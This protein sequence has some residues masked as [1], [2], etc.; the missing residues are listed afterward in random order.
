VQGVGEVDEDERHI[1]HLSLNEN[2]WVLAAQLQDETCKRLH[3]VLMREP[4][5]SEGKRIHD[6]YTLK[7]NRVYKVTPDGLPW[8]VPKTARTVFYHHD[9]VGHFGVDKTLDLVRQ[10]YW[11]PQMEKYNK[12]YVSC[13]L[14]CMYKK[15]PTGKQPG[16]LHPIPK[17]DVPLHTIHLDHL[18][19]FVSSTR[20]NAYLLVAI[21]GFTKFAFLKAV[22]NTKVGPALKF[23]DEIFNMFGVTQRI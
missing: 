2:D 10:K 8:V 21:D 16:F 18:G 20:N 3:T 4:T 11:F 22:R 1:F 9:N 12:R 5:D 14:A 19:P 6:E 13:C 17:F 7:Q 15:E 23:L